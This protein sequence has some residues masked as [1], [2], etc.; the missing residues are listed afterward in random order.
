MDELTTEMKLEIG[1]MLQEGVSDLGIKVVIDAWKR[2][3]AI[4]P[5]ATYAAYTEYGLPPINPNKTVEGSLVETD[6]TRLID[7]ETGSTE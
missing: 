7:A 3:R 4:D 2:Q 1:R 6:E 5:H